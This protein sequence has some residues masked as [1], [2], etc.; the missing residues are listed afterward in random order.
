MRKQAIRRMQEKRRLP[1]CAGAE[2]APAPEAMAQW[3]IQATNFIQNYFKV[4][5][6]ALGKVGLPTD[7]SIDSANLWL[8]IIREKKVFS[9]ENIQQLLKINTDA[10]KMIALPLIGDITKKL[11]QAGISTALT[12]AGPADFGHALTMNQFDMYWFPNAEPLRIR[13]NADMNELARALKE[14]RK[15]IKTDSDDEDNDS[16]AASSMPAAPPVP[17]GLYKKAIQQSLEEK[18]MSAEISKVLDAYAGLPQ[19]PEPKNVVWTKVADNIE[20]AKM[21][22]AVDPMDMISPVPSF[23][24]PKQ[25]PAGS[26]TFSVMANLISGIVSQLLSRAAP[27]E[28]PARVQ[29]L[30]QAQMPYAEKLAMGLRK[31]LMSSKPKTPSTSAPKSGQSSLQTLLKLADVGTIFSTKLFSSAEFVDFAERVAAANMS[32][33]VP[34]KNDQ[35]TMF[36]EMDE[37]DEEDEDT[38]PPS[39]YVVSDR[40]N[41]RVFHLE[42]PT[43]NDA[44]ARAR[45]QNGM[46]RGPS[47]PPRAYPSKCD[48]CAVPRPRYRTGAPPDEEAKSNITLTIT[49]FPGNREL[50]LNQTAASTGTSGIQYTLDG[51]IYTYYY[52]YGLLRTPDGKMHTLQQKLSR[53]QNGEWNFTATIQTSE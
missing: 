35:R 45:I 19:T 51:K 2:T 4:I 27:N 3:Q 43:R 16:P 7:P 32:A 48:A 42:P 9:P 52:N 11:T 18:N 14:R 53:G 20:K 46:R 28:D 37:E 49:N 29:A 6:G 31:E 10:V 24:P 34:S 26:A 5:L 33:P 1:V 13:D 41:P 12:V 15:V 23:E 47:N 40:S 22:A 21:V 25:A 36:I 30:V 38:M 17:A 8:K 39:G 50:V 44:P